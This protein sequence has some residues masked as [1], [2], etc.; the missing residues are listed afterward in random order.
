MIRHTHCVILSGAAQR[1][2][3]E[4]RNQSLPRSRT[5]K[6]RRQAESRHSCKALYSRSISNIP[7]KRNDTWVVPPQSST[8]LNHFYPVAGARR[9]PTK[10]S[11]MG[12]C[13]GA[14]G[15]SSTEYGYTKI[16]T[17]E[18]QGAKIPL[19]KV[20]AGKGRLSRSPLQGL[21]Q[22]PKVFFCHF[23]PVAERVKTSAFR[24]RNAARSSRK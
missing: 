18:K 5:P 6:G 15:N 16:C 23:Y 19:I 22:S 4:R 13:A 10:S 21:G 24:W 7:L 3:G 8:N 9:K 20:L 14:A 11:S 12:F 17:N 2:N 1:C